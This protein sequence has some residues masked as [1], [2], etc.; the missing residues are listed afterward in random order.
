MIGRRHSYGLSIDGSTIGADPSCQFL[1][2]LQRRWSIKVEQVAGTGTVR[3]AKPRHW[4]SGARKPPQ[5]R[6]PI[7]FA[8]RI[9]LQEPDVHHAGRPPQEVDMPVETTRGLK[10]MAK[11]PAQPTGSQGTSY[12]AVKPGAEFTA[13]QT[14]HANFSALCK[15]EHDNIRPARGGQKRVG[16]AITPLMIGSDPYRLPVGTRR[17]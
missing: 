8:P 14:P 1:K 17:A 2:R 5:Q 3:C 16:D 4:D 13:P 15:K 12:I 11:P 10:V 6:R 7:V 9:R